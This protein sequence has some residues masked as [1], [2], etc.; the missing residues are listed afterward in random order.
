MS[1]ID[2]D[3]WRRISAELDVLLEC[4]EDEQ[5]ARLAA[6]RATDPTFADAVAAMLTAGTKARDLHFL[7]GSVSPAAAAASPEQAFAGTLAGQRLGAWE[8]VDMLGQGGSGSVWRAR[9]SDGRFDGEAAIKLLHPSLLDAGGG[10]RFRREGAILGRLAHPHIAHLMDAGVSPTG[11][12]YLVLE[13]VAGERID[14]HCDAR[15]LGV[16]ARLALFFQVFDAVGFAHRHLVVHR[17]IKPGN[18]LVSRE[19][20]VQLLD[21]GI[22]KLLDGDGDSTADSAL[23]RDAGRWLTPEYAAP[24]QLRGEP[25]TTA[26]DIYS[27]GMLLF[28]LL[29]GVPPRA[30]QPGAGDGERET[31]TAALSRTSRDEPATAAAI[32]SARGTTLDELRHALGGDLQ[33]VLAMALA[34]SPA[35]RYASVDAFAEDV[36]RCLAHEPVA[37]RAPAFGYRL[38][39]FVRRHRGGVAAAAV[40]LLAI[41]GGVAGTLTQ[42]RRAEASDADAMRERDRAVQELVHANAAR[43]LIGFLLTEG[44]AS[45]QT[46]QQLLARAGTMVER[47]FA[48]DAALR[49]RLHETLAGEYMVLE[50]NALAAAAI[51]RALAAA[52]QVRDPRLLGELQCAQAAI[53]NQAGEFEAARKQVDVALA[54]LGPPTAEVAGAMSL[55]IASRA[56]AELELG[57]P[58]R[59]FAD[60][61]RAVAL[62]SNP[63]VDQQLD[64]IYVRTRLADMQAR[65]GDYPGAIATYEVVL[66]RMGAMGR[67][68]SS[69]AASTRNNLAVLLLNAG[70]LAR[71][72]VELEHSMQ[73]TREIVGDEGLNPI[74]EVNYAGAILEL[75]RTAEATRR[76]ERALAFSQEHAGDRIVGFTAARAAAAWCRAG[77]AARCADRLALGRRI[78]ATFLPPGH[79]AFGSVA[80]TAAALAQ[81]R[82]DDAGA[83]TELLGALAV[84]DAAEELNPMGTVARGMLA[85]L[86]HRAGNLPLAATLSGR[87]VADARAYTRGLPA[88]EWLGSALLT[89]AT[90]RSRPND[91]AQARQLATEAL[92]Q[93]RGSLGDAAPATREAATLLARLGGTPGA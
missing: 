93:L 9:R 78:L 34:P 32:A 4:T 87:A 7:T 2:A 21:F 29:A 43:E 67:E 31:L 82:K 3:Q 62:L 63:R 57:E 14:A 25:I 60:A 13:L 38:R 56:V 65:L 86:E 71:A 18:V 37:A 40:L 20:Q 52:K 54:L 8:L 72:T 89:A 11:Q 35:G 16:A 79:S 48:R 70:L 46:P 50:E 10:E 68:R 76:L 47:Q 66:R 81:L 58:G 5:A 88:S 30:L 73:I 12:P 24:E 59:A 84:F 83:R 80:V 75:G 23:T 64:A 36:R 1:D 44:S 61:K 77:D 53:R 15:T 69:I 45:Q 6:L 39:R 26:S 42:A 92:A 19:G 51:D 28:E 17:D 74:T 27:I 55:C 90:V 91:V 33:N 49:A 85:R 22:A 41:V